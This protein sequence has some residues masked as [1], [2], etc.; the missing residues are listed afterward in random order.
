MSGVTVA[1]GPMSEHAHMSRLNSLLSL[2]TAVRHCFCTATQRGTNSSSAL[3]ARARPT[4]K[5]MLPG[6]SGDDSVVLSNPKQT[7]GHEGCHRHQHIRTL[8]CWKAPR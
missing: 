6:L 2:L 8:R 1:A 5:T 7:S 4:A 3:C